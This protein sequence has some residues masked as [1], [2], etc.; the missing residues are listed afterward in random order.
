[1]TRLAACLLLLQAAQLVSAIEGLYSDTS[2]CEEIVINFAASNRPNKSSA[3][4][5]TKST[6]PALQGVN[7]NDTD[8]PLCTCCMV[9]FFT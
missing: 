5:V 7:D 8:V 6:H 2:R 9:H 4:F 1:M 3:A